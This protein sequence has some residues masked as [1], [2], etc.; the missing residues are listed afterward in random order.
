MPS[1]NERRSIDQSVEKERRSTLRRIKSDRR[2]KS[3]PVKNGR[4]TIA[5]RMSDIEA[6]GDKAIL[7]H[8]NRINTNYEFDVHIHYKD[9]KLIL[10]SI[11]VVLLVITFFLSIM[12]I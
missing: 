6:L 4:R 2:V 8:Q 1:S 9:E 10:Q 7:D 5:R 11:I 12:Q 3:I